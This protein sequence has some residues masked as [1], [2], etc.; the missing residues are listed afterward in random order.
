[1][2]KKA[3]NFSIQKSIGV[4]VVHQKNVSILKKRN[5]LVIKGQ[6]QVRGGKT[7]KAYVL[8]N[9]KYLKYFLSNICFFGG[10]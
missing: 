1:L 9:E 4:R 7:V 5:A 10:E 2:A 6:G 3:R 8:Q